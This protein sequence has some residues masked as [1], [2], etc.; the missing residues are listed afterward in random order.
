MYLGQFYIINQYILLTIIPTLLISGVIISFKKRKA[1]FILLNFL[2]FFA[3]SLI[4]FN[5]YTLQNQPIAFKNLP[6]DIKMEGRVS[7]HPKKWGKE[8]IYEVSINKI[9]V[10]GNETKI[11]KKIELKTRSKLKRDDF[12]SFFPKKEEKKINKVYPKNF[13]AKIFSFRSKIY[14]ILKNTYYNYLGFKHASLA[15]AF[16]LGNRLNISQNILNNFKKAGIFHLLAISGLHLSIL[17]FLFLKIFNKA[18][19][20]FMPIFFSLLI[21]N[22]IV[23]IKASLIRASMMI[24]IVLLSRKEGREYR[25]ENIFFISFSFL[26]IANPGFFHDLGFWLSFV[27]MGAIIFIYPLIYRLIGKNNYILRLLFISVSIIIATLPLNA[28]FFKLVP[29]SSLVSNICVMPAFYM[30]LVL[31]IFSSALTIIWPPLGGMALNLSK[32]FFI[33]TLKVTEFLGKMDFLTLYFENFP[34]KMI[35]IYYILLLFL[36]LLLYKYKPGDK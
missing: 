13:S 15:E 20:I 5:I 17:I 14:G 33:Y 1:F 34:V 4:S 26:L 12:I 35:T 28:Y 3:I 19:N 23:G 7:S 32:P 10:K 29:F 36:L 2:F 24:L 8:Y 6:E 25:S 18:K 27:S 21:F 11:D 22:F 30:L 16:V 9:F 31:L